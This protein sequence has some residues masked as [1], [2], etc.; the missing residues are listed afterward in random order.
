[1]GAELI[2][3]AKIYRGRRPKARYSVHFLRDWRTKA[4]MDR[5]KLA[6]LTGLAPQT[7]GRIENRQIQLTQET[8][9][10][11]AKV[12]KIPR[13]ALFEKPNDGKRQ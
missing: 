13:G 9:D 8:I 2:M 11:F 5:R 7:I 12:L 1:M 3:A 6:E 4:R 10:L